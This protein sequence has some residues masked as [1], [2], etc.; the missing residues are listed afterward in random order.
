MASGVAGEAVC[1][2]VGR[3]M[4]VSVGTGADVAVGSFPPQAPRATAITMKRMMNL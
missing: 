4:G 2:A 1:V 3:I